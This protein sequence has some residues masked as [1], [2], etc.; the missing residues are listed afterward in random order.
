MMTM[1]TIMGKK[2]TIR[3]KNKKRATR[4]K[5]KMMKTALH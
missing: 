2:K 5:E 3:K 1:A 4:R